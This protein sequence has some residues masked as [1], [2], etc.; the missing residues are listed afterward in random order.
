MRVVPMAPAGAQHAVLLARV[1][2]HPRNE[3]VLRQASWLDQKKN[4]DWV[5]SR[6]LG[7]CT[8]C[9]LVL[10]FELNKKKKIKRNKR[11]QTL[12]PRC[13]RMKDVLREIEAQ[14]AATKCGSPVCIENSK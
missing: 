14:R 5:P 3:V 1:D 7:A 8:A 6:A 2:R 10:T 4:A 9:A 11:K 12:P 13:W